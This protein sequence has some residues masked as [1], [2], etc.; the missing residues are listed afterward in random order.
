M[1]FLVYY[2]KLAQHR[3]FLPINI[4]NN[5]WC[6]WLKFQI[7]L[8]W[9]LAG[10]HLRFLLKSSFWGFFCL[11]NFDWTL[12][13]SFKWKRDD[14]KISYPAFLWFSHWKFKEVDKWNWIYK[15][16]VNWNELEPF[17]DK[18][19]WEYYKWWKFMDK[20]IKTL[21]EVYDN[22]DNL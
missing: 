16:I 5:L 11:H 10:C 8:T 14:K 4:L 15:I 3:S 12:L 2:Y 1:F 13:F 20:H 19:I 7:V 17:S 6:L 22:W 21:Q 18:S 9:P